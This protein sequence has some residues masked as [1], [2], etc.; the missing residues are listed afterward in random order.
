M[1]RPR[2]SLGVTDH[3]LVRWLERSGAM[4]M[5][6]MRDMLAA[7]LERAA[8]A[9]E[10]LGISKFLILADGLVFV[11]DEGTCVTVFED[12]GRGARHSKRKRQRQRRR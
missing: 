10:V 5:E 4:D 11:I 2:S 8:Q 7:S 3:G 1:D 6:A 9:A 12:R